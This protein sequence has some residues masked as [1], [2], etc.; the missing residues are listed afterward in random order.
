MIP[1]VEAFIVQ[2]MSHKYIEPPTFDLSLSYK[3]SSFFTPMVF[4]LS[5][6]ADPMALLFRFA[7]EEGAYNYDFFLLIKDRQLSYFN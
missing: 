6:G 3:D 2:Y 5:P 7:D 4:V 1:A